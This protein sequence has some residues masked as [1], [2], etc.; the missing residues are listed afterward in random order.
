MNQPEFTYKNVR[1][2][3]D[4]K[5]F[6]SPREKDFVMQSIPEYSHVL[7]NNESDKGS[8]NLPDPNYRSSPDI[9]FILL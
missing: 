7:C 4:G 8:I 1:V 5:Q 9:T 3:Q 6:V 2:R